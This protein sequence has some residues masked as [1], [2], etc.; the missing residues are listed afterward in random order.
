MKSNYLLMLG[1][2]LIV[3]LSFTSFT[4]ATIS[5]ITDCVVQD[6]KVITAVYDGHEDYGYNFI[7]KNTNDDE[8]TIT[9]QNINSEV[10]EAFDLNSETH[11]GSKF[12]VSFTTVIDVFT[13]GDGFEDENEI[14]TI[15]QLE[16][17]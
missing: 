5:S 2:L 11:V 12:K 7:A 3:V 9:F 14:N 17:L 1:S 4:N 6:T 10:L 15:T 13:D 16:K 8:Y